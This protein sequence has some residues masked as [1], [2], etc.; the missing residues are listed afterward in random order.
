MTAQPTFHKLALH[1][2]ETNGMVSITCDQLDGFFFSA[3]KGG[4]IRERLQRMLKIGYQS[5]GQSVRTYIN[6]S[7]SQDTIHAVVE[8]IQKQEKQNVSHHDRRRLH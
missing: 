6:G 7:V 2:R 8:M 5:R 4:R 1:R 3:K